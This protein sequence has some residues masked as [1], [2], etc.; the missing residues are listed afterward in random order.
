[1]SAAVVPA[2]TGAVALAALLA[3]PAVAHEGEPHADVNP[4]LLQEVAVIEAAGV[5][6]AEQLDVA[7]IERSDASCGATVEF[8]DV[9]LG[10]RT[11]DGLLRVEL[12]GGETITTHGPDFAHPAQLTQSLSVGMAAA[13]RGASADDVACVDPSTPHTVLVYAVPHDGRD[14]AVATIPALRQATYEASAVFDNQSRLLESSSD[15]RLRVACTGGEPTVLVLRLRHAATDSDFSTV[16]QDVRAMT[17][18]LS[19]VGQRRFLVF[20]DA[21]L[22]D[23]GGI[24][25]WTNDERVGGNN[26]NNYGGYVALQDNSERLG[27]NWQI[28]LHEAAHNMGAVSNSA[29]NT[30]GLNE[31]HCH[32][33][34]D[35]MCY[36]DSGALAGAYDDTV[37]AVVELDCNND[38]YYHPAPA[39]GTHLAIRWNVASTF[40]DYLT[41]APV[42]RDELAPTVP[43]GLVAEPHGDFVR[44]TWTAS[45]DAGTGVAGYRVYRRSAGVWTSAR[46]T[47]LASTTVDVSSNPSSTLDLRLTAFDHRGNE[48]A[49]IELA[50]IATGPTDGTPQAFG[51]P[52]SAPPTNLQAT[53]DEFDALWLEWELPIGEPIDFTEVSYRVQGEV[54]WVSYGLNT[55]PTSVDPLDPGTTYEFAVQSMSGMGQLSARTTVVATTP[56]VDLLPTP[57]APGNLAH[58]DIRGGTARLDWDSVPAASSYVVHRGTTYLGATSDTSFVV[59]GLPAGATTNVHVRARNV[60]L[61]ESAAATTS[62][63]TAAAPDTT[64]PPGPSIDSWS[65]GSTSITIGWTDAGADAD[66]YRVVAGELDEPASIVHDGIAGLTDTLTGL[67]PATKYVVALYSVDA[68][69]NTGNIGLYG[70]SGDVETDPSADTTPPAPPTDL[71]LTSATD[72]TLEVQ[73]TASPSG[74]VTGYTLERAVGVGWVMSATTTGTSATLTGL[75]PQT[76]HDLR[77][78][79]HDAGSNRSTFATLTASTTDGAADATPPTA[80]TGLNLVARTSSSITIGWTASTDDVGVAGYRVERSDGA[81]GWIDEGSTA[82][83]QRAVT[84]LPADTE[85]ELRVVARDASGNETPSTTATF[86]TLPAADTTPPT[87]PDAPTAVAR[88]GSSITL[89]WA[90]ATDDVG[91]AAYLLDRRSTSGT[92]QHIATISST[93]LTIGQLQQLTSY[94]HRVRARDAAGNVSAPSAATTASTLD[95]TAPDAPPNVAATVTRYDVRVEWDASS[96]AG[97]VATYVVFTRSEPSS[98]WAEQARIDAGSSTRQLT[99]PSL[100]PGTY[101]FA[102]RAIDVAGNQSPITEATATVR[103]V[104]PPTQPPRLRATKLARTSV[105]MQWN[106]ARDNVG[107][108]GYQVRCAGTPRVVRVPAG[109]RRRLCARLT[110]G[111]RYVAMVRAVDAAGQTS[112]WARLTVRTPR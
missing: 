63:T 48:S 85:Q 7:P 18:T 89:S 26:R 28:L 105:V 84:G 52:P 93:S 97:G 61:D 68:S 16:M 72:T 40:N 33:G 30:S 77:V 43:T 71:A 13:I 73:W 78:R 47:W 112:L 103:D 86:R 10:C 59:E 49:P 4:T 51:E 39:A 79:A 69:G 14:R 23:F 66:H 101:G 60:E 27:P 45:S 11:E 88:T 12:P 96:D 90:A 64:S 74:D 57:A 41:H 35:I 70:L 2:L 102:V 38:D 108:A 75:T 58:S 31:A 24:A 50:G 95:I 55:S 53:I 6:F 46:D 20:Y 62:V 80:A 25:Q 67:K 3:G 99:I 8:D 87:A 37:C 21:H 98:T 15:R 91:V 19:G 42:T 82:S 92:W 76:S 65:F 106:P 56:G 54:D 81:G 22:G 100:R 107:V 83:L 109:L 111:R 36:D 9:G 29:P 32:D 94:T 104:T 44:L 17:G 110:P 1:M 5:Q 34:R